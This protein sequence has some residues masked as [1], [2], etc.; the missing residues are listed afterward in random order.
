MLHQSEN[1]VF[2]SD[3]DGKF[4]GDFNSGHWYD[5]IHK[6]V[7]P[8]LLLP[9]FIYLDEARVKNTDLKSHPFVLINGALPI[10]LRTLRKNMYIYGMVPPKI[11]SPFVMDIFS[12]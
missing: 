2:N 10:E 1:M 3:Y 12:I 11:P 9:I 6:L 7:A 4:F 8:K 5:Q